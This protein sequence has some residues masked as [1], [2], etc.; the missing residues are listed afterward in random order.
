MLKQVGSSRPRTY[1]DEFFITSSLAHIS[2]ISTP[3]TPNRSQISSYGWSAQAEW[4]YSPFISENETHVGI[5]PLSSLLWKDCKKLAQHLE[6]KKIYWWSPRETLS[7]SS[8]CPRI[9]HRAELC[10]SQS[11]AQPLLRHWDVTLPFLF[12]ISLKIS[13]ISLSGDFLPPEV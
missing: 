11:P 7:I 6:T 8:A 2:C 10:G 5:F 3:S 4:F 13:N 12:W 1:S 9:C